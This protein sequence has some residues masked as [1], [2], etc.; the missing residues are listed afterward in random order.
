MRLDGRTAVVT[1]GGGG[2]G[3]AICRALAAEG[4]RVAV[5][6]QRL[7]AARAVAAEIAAAGGRAGAWSFDVADAD[8]VER[9]ADDIERELG[10]LQAWVNNAG[11]SVIVPFLECTDQAWEKTLAVNLT[12]AFVGC[13]AALRRMAPRGAGSLINMSSQSGKTGSAQYAAYC[14]SK[15]GVIGLTQSLAVEFAPKGIR[16]NA[17]CPGVVFTPLWDGM[18]ED[19]ARKRGMRP[20][21]VRP[22]LESRI[23]LGRLCAPEDVAAMAVFLVSDESCYVTGQALNLSGGS[24]TH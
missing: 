7:E 23:P 22:Y 16:V 24:E 12:G 18:L 11:V 1:G 4:A 20:E 6:D 10:P 17:I 13:R 8:A 5:C 3:A 15:F 14:A 19:Y 21:E 2:I 9:A